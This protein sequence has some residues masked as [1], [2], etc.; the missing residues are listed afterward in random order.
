MVRGVRCLSPLCMAKRACA[1]CARKHTCKNMWG[2]PRLMHTCSC[3]AH[4][5]Q[6]IVR[7]HGC[8]PKWHLGSAV[9]MR[10]QTLG[11]PTDQGWGGQQACPGRGLGVWDMTGWFLG[12][13]RSNDASGTLNTRSNLSCRSPLVPWATPQHH[14]LIQYA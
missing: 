1:V 13:H 10:D 2:Q 11:R 8:S 14:R 5:A 6:G 9:R 3:H 12:I 7:M 4:S